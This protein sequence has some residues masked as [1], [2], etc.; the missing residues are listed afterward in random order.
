MKHQLAVRYLLEQ[1]ALIHKMQ[2]QADANLGLHGI[3]FTEYLIM[4]HLDKALNKTMRRIELANV[5]GITASGVTRL[6]A[7]MERNHIVEKQANPRDAR[8][9]LVKLTTVGAELY[10]HATVTVG[11][12]ADQLSRSLT[13]KDLK[14]G[15]KL[16]EQWAI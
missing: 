4:Y 3:S 2:R 14:Q 10:D 1:A 7:P 16:N 8:V 9:S 5:V 6:L 13:V 11:H 12:F 15:L